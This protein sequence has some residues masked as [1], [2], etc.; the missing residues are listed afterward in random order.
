MASLRSI[1]GYAQCCTCAQHNGSKGHAARAPAGPAT[2]RTPCSIAQKHQ[3]VATPSRVMC[4]AAQG[5][6]PASTALSQFTNLFPLWVVLGCLSGLFGQQLYTSWYKPVYVTSML[7]ITMLCMGFT[8]SVE[9]M[10]N[11]MKTPQR[12]MTG[13]VLQY[14]IMPA[15]GFLISRAPN[16]PPP[17]AAGIIL[18]ACC[19]GGCATF[20]YGCAALA[21]LPIL[22]TGHLAGHQLSVVHRRVRCCNNFYTSLRRTASNIITYLA[23]ADVGL[24]VMMTT[25]STLAAVVMTPLLTTKLIGTMVPVDGMALFVSTLQVRSKRSCLHE[26]H[27]CAV[28]ASSP[29]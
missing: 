25:A 1:M 18:V 4:R 12:V 3:R 2:E 9:D 21:I 26:Q 10:T 6:A 15:L 5:D 29:Q 24:S 8:L 22:F 7:A 20:L 27:A 19:P 17:F 28:F 11:V 13:A 14:S 16:L 23:R